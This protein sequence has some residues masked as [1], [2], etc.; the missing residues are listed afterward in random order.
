MSKE[1][2]QGITEDQLYQQFTKSNQVCTSSFQL[3]FESAL[4]LQRHNMF[5]QNLLKVNNIEIPKP[6]SAPSPEMKKPNR[7]ERRRTEKQNKKKA[8]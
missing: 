7:A 4:E 5:L 2:N 6:T 1:E 3:L 8:K